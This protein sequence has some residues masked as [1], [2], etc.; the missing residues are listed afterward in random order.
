MTIC[1]R[2]AFLK[3]GLVNRLDGLW[4]KIKVFC[5]IMDGQHLAKF[6]NVLRHPVCHPFGSIDKTEMFDSCPIAVVAPD[7]AVF[8]LKPDLG[9]CHIQVANKAVMAVRMN[10]SRRRLAMMTQRTISKIGGYPNHRR[11]SFFAMNRL[12]CNFHSHKREILCY[13]KLGHCATPF[14]LQVTFSKELIS[15]KVAWCPLYFIHF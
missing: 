6:V 1:T 2:K 12:F 9:F 7:F 13:T 15:R 4:V 14:V 3:K 11:V 8:N 5:D 10:R